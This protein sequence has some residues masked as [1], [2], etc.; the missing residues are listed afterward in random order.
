[1]TRRT[2]R[3]RSVRLAGASALLLPLA[4]IAQPTATAAPVPQ[5]DAHCSPGAHS[6]ESPGSVMYPDTGNGGYVSVHTDVTLRYNAAQNLFLPGTHVVLSDRATQCLSSLSLDFERTEA[7]TQP[8]RPDMH[9]ASVAVNGIPAHFRFVQPTYPGDPHGMSDPDPR[10]HEVSQTNPVGGPKHN[11]LPPACSPSFAMPARPSATRRTG[12]SARRTSCSSRRAEPIADGTS[13]TVTVNYTGHPGL[14]DDADGSREGWFTTAGGSSMDTEPMGSEDWMPLNNFPTAKPSYDFYETAAKGKTVICNGQ[15][16]ST[17]TNKPDKQFP[18]GSAT[19]HWHAPM[20]INSYLPLSIIGDYKLT[21]RHTADGMPYYEAQDTH[22]PANKQAA[23]QQVMNEQEAITKFEETYNG[24]FPFSSDGV[25]AA[26]PGTGGVVEEMETMI[27]FT[28]G[29]VGLGTLYHENMH[30]WWGDHVSEGSYEMTFFKEGLATLSQVLASA[31][32]QAAG[33]LLAPAS[34]ASIDSTLIR[35]FDREYA[36]HGTFWLRAPSNPAPFTLFNTPP[37]YNRPATA[38]VALYQILGR[39]RFIKAL[40]TI[41]ADYGGGNITEP[42][43]EKEFQRFLPNPSDECITRLGQ[44]FTEWFDTGYPVGHEP[45]ITGPG[46]HGPDFY[47]GV[48]TPT[49]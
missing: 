47:N 33:S 25:V 45:D 8:G 12:S 46:L 30:Q 27:V 13:F 38:Y 22:I 6:L 4:A 3:V 36:N 19:W 20:P 43:L 26:I 14:H 5:A 16:E 2:S 9:V 1:M 40:H 49:A 28:R 24:A 42:Q 41:Q 48:C 32:R 39:D 31:Q 17:T 15:L 11:P 21:V 37:T 7:G 35:W 18:Q 44:F 10:A 23:N 34:P 29:H